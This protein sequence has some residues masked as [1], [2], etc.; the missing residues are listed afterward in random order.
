MP[1]LIIYADQLGTNAIR[2]RFIDLEEFKNTVE[3][4]V[5]DQFNSLLH[6]NLVAGDTVRTDHFQTSKS[7]PTSILVVILAWWNQA[8]EQNAEELSHLIA[9]DIHCLFESIAPGPKIS[10]LLEVVD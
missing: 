2:D 1:H 6:E 8:R 10:V 5:A 9:H 3:R 7:M 4:I